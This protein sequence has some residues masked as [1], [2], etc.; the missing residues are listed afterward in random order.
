MAKTKDSLFDEI[1]ETSIAWESTPEAS[2][3]PE[4][5]QEREDAVAD[6]RWRSS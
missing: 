5:E 6:T 1:V 4:A 2:L 3:K